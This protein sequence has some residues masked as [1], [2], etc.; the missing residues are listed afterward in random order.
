MSFVWWVLTEAERKGLKRLYFLSR[1]GYIMYKIVLLFSE[2][3]NLNIDCRY[4]YGSRIAWRTAVYGLISEDEKYKYIFSGGYKITPR[5]ILKRVQADK[6]QRYEIYRDIDFFDSFESENQELT[7]K[8]LKILEDK[9]KSSTVFGEY[10]R[11]IS[12]KQLID[13]SNYF[14]QEGLFDGGEIAVV[15]SG[16]TGTI[17]RNLRQ[18]L[19]HNMR[20]PKISGYYFG[21]YAT[22][23]DKKDG[24]YNAWYF[25]PDSPVNLMTSFNNNVFECMCATPFNM[26]CG[27][28]YSHENRCFTPV[29]N[30][31]GEFNKRKAEML[32]T[33]IEEYTAQYLADSTLKFEDYSGKYLE[34]SKKILQRFMLNPSEEEART[35]GDFRFCDD[36]SDSYENSLARVVDEN[37]LKSYNIFTR[38]KYKLN[39]VDSADLFWFHGSAAMSKINKN[40][41]WYKLNYKLWETI[42]L[43]M[44]KY[45]YRER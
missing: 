28:E 38:I 9:L 16:W 37:Y 39:K 12:S 11:Y 6:T 20:K 19:E 15:D 14:G 18:I 24:E 3:F 2:H 31:S 45:K 40:L 27:Y 1:D 7:P 17:Q 30:N 35:F 29:F 21:L 8:D 43:L 34:R 23:G 42:R 41:T 4:L 10:L 25:S 5:I 22:S 13:V 44:K 32:N 36:S 33:Y 26:T